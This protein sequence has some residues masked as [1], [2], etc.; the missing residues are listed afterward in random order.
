MPELIHGELSYKIVGVLFRVYNELGGGHLEKY[1]QK[2]ISIALKEHNIPF[3]EQVPAPLAFASQKIGRYFLDF[4]IDNKIVLEIKA[5]H[6]F[7][8]RDFRQVT[9]YLQATDLHLAI[10]AAFTRSGVIFQRVLPG[11]MRARKRKR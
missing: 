3:Q 2:A 7:F 4:V 8:P 5:H 6:G 9:A 1:Y 11:T 10:L